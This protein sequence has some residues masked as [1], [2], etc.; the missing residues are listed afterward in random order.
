MGFGQEQTLPRDV[1]YD[2]SSIRSRKDAVPR[3]NRAKRGVVIVMCVNWLPKEADVDKGP[4]QVGPLLD[5]AAQQRS[6]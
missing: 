4:L 1:F 3:R 2:R 6:L 5:A